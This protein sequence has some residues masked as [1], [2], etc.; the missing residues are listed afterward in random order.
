M[1]DIY[2]EVTA[3]GIQGL[4]GTGTNG[5][6]TW[7]PTLTYS[8][9]DIVSYEGNLYYWISST[10]GNSLTN[11]SVATSEWQ[12]STGA[13][14]AGATGATGPAGGPTGATG[15][16]GHQGASGIEIGRAHV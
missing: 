16:T 1:A 15:A 4:S 6:A 5:V 12:V 13:G 2:A 7:D 8:Q 11:P 9:Y 3:V 14:G 10:P